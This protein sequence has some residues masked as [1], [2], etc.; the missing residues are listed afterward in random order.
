[1]QVKGKFSAVSVPTR[2]AKRGIGKGLVQAAEEKLLEVAKQEFDVRVQQ[3][4]VEES[5][6]TSLIV[7]MEMGVI[8]QRTDLFPWYE[9][10]GY[11]TIGEIHP[12]DEEVTRICLEGVD[13]CCVLMRKNLL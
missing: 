8:N 2:F 5:K 1:M 3:A 6:P 12:N 10:Q 7:T 9:S 11:V 4:Q 13:I